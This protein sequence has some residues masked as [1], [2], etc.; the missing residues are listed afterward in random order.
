MK[1]WKRLEIL[2]GLHKLKNFQSYQKFSE[3]DFIVLIYIAIEP[4]FK[5]CFRID[6]FF[7]FWDWGKNPSQL[8]TMELTDTIEL[9]DIADMCTCDS[10]L[11]GRRYVTPLDPSSKTRGTAIRNTPRSQFRAR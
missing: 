10:G 11:G 9:T 8:D 3:N 2:K 6:D 7:F 4:D 1:F 5:E